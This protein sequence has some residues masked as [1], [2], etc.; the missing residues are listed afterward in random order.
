MFTNSIWRYFCRQNS[1][2]LQTP[3]F[4]FKL[5]ALPKFVVM[6]LRLYRR[7]I[8]GAH[9]LDDFS[10]AVG[11]KSLNDYLLRVCHAVGVVFSSS[12]W[13]FTEKYE[14][15]FTI[16]WVIIRS[17]PNIYK[18]NLFSHVQKLGTPKNLHVTQIC[19]PSHI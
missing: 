5:A 13:E 15:L 10:V 16:I 2:R 11:S 9:N 8:Q 1:V 12:I 7:T 6:A 18:N 19:S 3:V 14:F 17:V 4:F